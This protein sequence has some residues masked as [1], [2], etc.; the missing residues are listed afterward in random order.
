MPALINERVTIDFGPLA[1]CIDGYP[2]AMFS[3]I[4]GMIERRGYFLCV[5]VKFDDAPVK[6]GQRLALSS[7]SKEPNKT[8]WTLRIKKRLLPNGCFDFVPLQLNQWKNGI[9]QPSID[10]TLQDVRSLV[11]AWWGE[12]DNKPPF[13]WSK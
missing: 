7:L 2:G 9:E 6:K 4:D 8:V 12:T 10:V 11:N 13:S 3:D 1:G 5:E